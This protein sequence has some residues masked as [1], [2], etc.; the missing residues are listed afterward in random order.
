MAATTTTAVALRNIYL[1]HQRITPQIVVDESRPEDAPLHSRFEWDDEVAGEAFRRQQ[2]AQMIRSVEVTF[3][4]SSSGGGES[5]P[6]R[7]RQYVPTRT[8]SDGDDASGEYRA[9]EDV[10]RDAQSVLL[11]QMEREWRNLRRRW[12]SHRE[13]FDAMVQRDLGDAA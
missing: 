1:Q 5:R 7:V 9:V 4:P 3:Q 2:A 6:V 12:E 10:P 11:A 13:Y 8:V